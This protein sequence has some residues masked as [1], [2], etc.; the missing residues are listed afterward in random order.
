MPLKLFALNNSVTRAFQTLHVSEVPEILNNRHL[1]SLD[2]F[3]GISIMIVVISHLVLYTKNYALATIF[4]GTLGVHVF[5]VIS[6]FLI[7]TLLLKERIEHNGIQLR[8]FYIRRFLRIF[9]VAYLFI[10][11]IIGL[12]IIFGLHVSMLEIIGSVFY[13]MNF[14]YFRQN[15]SWYTE[16]YWSLSIEEQFYLLF[17]F[18]LKKSIKTYLLVMLTLAV[19]V[20]LTLFFL[21]LLHINNPILAIVLKYLLKFNGIAVGSV[22][23]FLLFKNKIPVKNLAKYK[24]YLNLVLIPVIFM[25]KVNPNYSVYTALENAFVA[26]LIAIIIV[27]NL[28]YSKGITYRFLNS[29]I[30]IN[31]GILSYSIYIWQQL[32]TREVPWSGKFLFSDSMLLNMVLLLGVSYLSYHYYEKKFLKLKDKFQNYKPFSINKSR[33]K[34]SQLSSYGR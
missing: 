16:H 8:N 4:N 28:V 7:T 6:G 31:L 14:S 23:S 32:F 18:I 3:R 22:F 10:A 9:P 29:R 26:I 25:V 17:P 19:I 1:P 34:Y 11:C 24:L 30:L 20:P 15:G 2:G 33:N 13:L 21:F 12:N 5:F 27:S